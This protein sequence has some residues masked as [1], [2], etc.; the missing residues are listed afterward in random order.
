MSQR[1]AQWEASAAFMCALQFALH[2]QGFV[3]IWV[4]RQIP[5]A[6]R[7]TSLQGH[8]CPF[9]RQQQWPVAAVQDVLIIKVKLQ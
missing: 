9:S 2:T 1:F 7:Q 8:Q 4:T 6:I 5:I 3:V